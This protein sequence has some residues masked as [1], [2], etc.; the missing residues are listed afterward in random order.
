MLGY[1]RERE[2]G[3][4]SKNASLQTIHNIRLLALKQ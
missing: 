3:T 2:K 4:D 1:G